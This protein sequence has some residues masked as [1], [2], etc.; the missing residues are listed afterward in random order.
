M[1]LFVDI[2]KPKAWPPPRNGE[3]FASE[4]TRELLEYGAKRDPIGDKFHTAFACLFIFCLP[5]ATYPS[6]IAM[7][8][9]CIY[10]L[11]RLPSTWRTLVPLLRSIVFWSIILWGAWSILTMTWTSD[12]AMAK[13]HARSMR[14]ICIPVL[15]IPI[16]RRWP[17]FIAFGLLGVAVQN[18]TQLS[19][20]IGSWFMGG[21]DW[22]TGGALFRP[23]GWDK[24]QGNAAMFMGFA[25]IVWLG[26]FI[27]KNTLTKWAVLGVLLALF[28]AVT[29]KSMAVGF[30]LVIAL[31][32]FGI[33]VIAQKLLRP[34]QIIAIGS[35]TAVLVFAAGFFG[36]ETISSRVRNSIDDAKGF[37]DGNVDEN[38]STQYRLHWWETTLS[39][40]TDEPTLRNVLVGHGLG[41]TRMIDFSKEGSVISSVAGHPHNTFLQILY[42]GGI[43]GLCLFIFMLWKIARG[44]KGISKA[45]PPVVFPVCASLVVLWSVA[46]FFESSQN[47]GR[48]LALLMLVGAFVICNSLIHPVRHSNDVYTHN[49]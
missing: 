7:W 35:M 22:K 36:S 27:G 26:V 23:V 15:L 47:S 25:V 29:S 43:T 49:R 5:I 34:K 3:E 19:E 6:S 30:G 39:H 11:L 2:P 18:A 14:M 1:G 13:D 10:S 46:A 21:V 44:A 42:E 16:A 41:N 28:G 24:H 20:V 31:A 17:L 48:P 38:N 32:L 45:W 12:I 40:V 8:I 37:V 33:F 9:I 4:R